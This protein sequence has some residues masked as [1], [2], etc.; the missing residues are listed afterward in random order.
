M[1]AVTIITNMGSEKN[2]VKGKGTLL[3]ISGNRF[4]KTRRLRSTSYVFGSLSQ[5][6]KSSK[7]LLSVI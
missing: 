2:E 4:T 6:S 1:V 3:S 7:F 5:S